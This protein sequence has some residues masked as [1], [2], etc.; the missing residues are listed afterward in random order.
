MSILYL[1]YLSFHTPPSSSTSEKNIFF[2]FTFFR[3]FLFLTAE[4]FHP[5]LSSAPLLLHLWPSRRAVPI[6]FNSF[7]QLTGDLTPC[8]EKGPYARENDTV[9]R[10][11][12]RKSL[13]SPSFCLFFFFRSSLLGIVFIV[14]PFDSF[15]KEKETSE[16]ESQA[17]QI[18]CFS[19]CVSPAFAPLRR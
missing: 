13:S 5:P 17:K 6:L 4:N 11:S 9:A 1:V 19:Y 7:R 8:G 10:F 15:Q 3:T 14:V 16:K 2:F 18:E 12:R